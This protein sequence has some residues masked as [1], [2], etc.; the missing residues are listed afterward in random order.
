MVLPEL[1]VILIARL[2]NSFNCL[3]RSHA[4]NSFFFLN[5]KALDEYHHKNHAFSN[6]CQWHSQYQIDYFMTGE[7][8]HLKPLSLAQ[9]NQT[10][11]KVFVQIPQKNKKLPVSCKNI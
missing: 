1:L 7:I 4:A 8:S 10:P 11:C 3:G 5:L 9:L 2:I 6:C